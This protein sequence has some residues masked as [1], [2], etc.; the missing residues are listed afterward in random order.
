[1]NQRFD[2]AGIQRSAQ[3]VGASTHSKAR[4]IT[5]RRAWWKLTL[6]RWA[7]RLALWGLK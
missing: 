3:R 7:L 2:A 5:A 6:A 1:M 4:V